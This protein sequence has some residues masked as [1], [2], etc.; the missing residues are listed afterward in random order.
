[1]NTF[2]LSLISNFNGNALLALFSPIFLRISIFF[3]S[4][5]LLIPSYTIFQFKKKKIEKKVEE[6]L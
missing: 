5:P 2:R 1:M 4:F 6:S 3:P